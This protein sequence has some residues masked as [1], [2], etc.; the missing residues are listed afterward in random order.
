M[1][2]KFQVST[3]LDGGG[4]MVS[5]LILRAQD[6]RLQVSKITAADF[7]R[8]KSGFIW[9]TAGQLA[10]KHDISYK[11]A[12]QIKASKDYDMYREQ[13]KA[14]HPEPQYSLADQV[15]YIHNLVFN[16]HDNKY[17]EPPTGR[18]AARELEIHFL[19]NK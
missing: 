18:Q 14:Q 12:V 9:R 19:G 15:K 8:I 5:S 11:T 4:L 6:G 2:S 7:K 10:A 1:L 13:V 17:I 16:K 3:K